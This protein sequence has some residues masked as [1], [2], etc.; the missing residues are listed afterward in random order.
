VHL[1]RHE[2]DGRG[3]AKQL[4]EELLEV[5]NHA[6]TVKETQRSVFTR[7][8]SLKPVQR[9]PGVYIHRGGVTTSHATAA[10]RVRRSQGES[11]CPMSHCESRRVSGSQRESGRFRT[12]HYRIETRARDGKIEGEASRDITPLLRS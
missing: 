8:T 11:E 7:R 4:K 6:H 12:G 9:K 3:F 1:S 2:D 5:V 10:L